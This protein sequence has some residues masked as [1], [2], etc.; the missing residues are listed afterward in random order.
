VRG[1]PHGYGEGYNSDGSIFHKG[2]WEKGMPGHQMLVLVQ[3]TTLLDEW[4]MAS[5]QVACDVSDPSSLSYPER[6]SRYDPY[7][8]MLDDS[9]GNSD[10][11]SCFSEVTTSLALKSEIDYDADDIRSH[12]DDQN[13]HEAMEGAVLSLG[14]HDPSTT[15]KLRNYGMENVHI[16]KLNSRHARMS[17]RS[18]HR[19]DDIGHIYG[20][21]IEI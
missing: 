21:R 13:H 17:R 3:P 8:R 2:Q 9:S 1:V 16:G 7:R 15:N 10:D 14:L 5:G 6:M 20:P 4:S 18:T 12:G 11:E 19:S